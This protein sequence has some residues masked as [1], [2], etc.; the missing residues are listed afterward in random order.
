MNTPEINLHAQGLSG[1]TDD[2]IPPKN[3]LYGSVFTSPV[4]HGM[5]VKLD[6]SAARK[7]PGVAGIFT[8]KDIPGQNQ[9]GDVIKDQQLLAEK[10]VFFI[11]Q[12]IAFVIAKSK[13]LADKARKLINLEIKNLELVIDE[14]ESF[15][16]GKLLEPARTFSIGNV[17]DTWK[18]CDVI[19][20]GS[21]KTGTQEHFYLETQ[22]ALAIPVNQ[23]SLKI[24]SA[25]QSP[26]FVQMIVSRIL[27]LNMNE[28]EVEVG[29]LGGGFPFSQ[30][31]T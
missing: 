23:K 19:V 7:S 31:A 22:S 11:G 12:P 20:E 30:T 29:R 6:F 1:Y 27:G 8:A 2:I 10:E 26:T 14:R 4:A 24:Y 15:K 25:T 28:I 13:D 3:T 9:I 18:K 5:I 17:A 21:C 16:K